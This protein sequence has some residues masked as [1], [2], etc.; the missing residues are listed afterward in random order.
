MAN[1]FSHAKKGLRMKVRMWSL[2]LLGCLFLFG[3]QPILAAEQSS[4]QRQEVRES[5]QERQKCPDYFPSTNLQQSAQQQKIPVVITQPAPMAS[6]VEVVE[7]YVNCC[8]CCL[9]MH[10]DCCIPIEKATE[11]G[12]DA[13][14]DSCATNCCCPCFSKTS[15]GEGRRVRLR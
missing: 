14:G 5:V 15:N 3:T 6:R 2:Y 1:I 7:A 9:F 8:P 10:P 11:R 4:L 12:G 13:C